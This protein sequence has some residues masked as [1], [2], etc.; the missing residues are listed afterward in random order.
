MPTT[1]FCAWCK[2]HPVLRFIDNIIL[3]ILIRSVVYYHVLS[4]L[5]IRLTFKFWPV[6]DFINILV[7]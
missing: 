1:Q 4:S 5:I 7:T 3:I 6:H 2:R